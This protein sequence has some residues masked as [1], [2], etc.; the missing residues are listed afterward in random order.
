MSDRITLIKERLASLQPESIEI[1]DDSHEHAG[2]AGARDGG[3]HFTVRIVSQAFSGQNLVKR[4]QAV[5][6]AVG[7]LMN[8]EIHALSI[9]AL[10]PE[11]V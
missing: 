8:T 5:Y 6:A 9:K 11:E 3:G 10:T 7:D 4:H 2:H 1:T